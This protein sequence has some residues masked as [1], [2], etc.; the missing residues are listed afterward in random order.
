MNSGIISITFDDGLKN[1]LEV[2]HPILAKFGLKATFYFVSGLVNRRKHLSKKD[3]LHLQNYGHE[4]GSHSASHISLPGLP[5]KKLAKEISGSKKS[6]EKM[7]IEISTFAYPFGKY[8]EQSKKLVQ[9]AGYKAARTNFQG[10]N[11]ADSDRFA[12]R[13]FNMVRKTEFAEAEK[14]IQEAREKKCWVIFCFH[15]IENGEARWAIAPQMLE[16]ICRSVADSRLKCATVRECIEFA[17][18]T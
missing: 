4:I 11:T 7:G 16:S 9:L 17:L 10:F 18:T 14:K 3:L 15:Q 5:E 1:H 12:L 8:D 2:A 13:T 6:L